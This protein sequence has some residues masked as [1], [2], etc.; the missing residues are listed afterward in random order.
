M[1]YY[2]LVQLQKL[3]KQNEDQ[4][5]TEE[6]EENNFKFINRPQESRTDKQKLQNIN[7]LKDLI[8]RG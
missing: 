1:M 3:T 2:Y 8:G 5:D 7:F 4:C 6:F